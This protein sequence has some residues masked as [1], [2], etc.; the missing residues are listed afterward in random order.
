MQI[1]FNIHPISWGLKGKLRERT[2]IEYE[3]EDGYDKE[4]ELIKIDHDIESEE[5][6]DLKLQLDLKYNKLSKEEYETMLIDDMEES[7][8]K[9]IKAFELLYKYGHIS[10]I[11]LEK[12]IA[13][14]KEEPWVYVNSE[15]N[16]EEGLDGFSLKLD[17]NDYY[18]DF[19]KEEGYE[20]NTDD[21]IM[22][23]WLTDVCKTVSVEEE[24]PYF[25][26]ATVGESGAIKVYE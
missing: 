10:D 20:G 3:M 4:I 15:Y 18:I 19:L 9:H 1:P 22:D 14:I 5:F 2:R 24:I 25:N 21:E 8:E 16:K 23:Q 26:P 17:W 11:E 13:T 7:D 12:E 6:K